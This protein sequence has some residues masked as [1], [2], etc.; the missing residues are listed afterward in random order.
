MGRVDLEDIAKTENIVALCDGIGITG[1]RSIQAVP[2][3]KRF[4]DYR[5]MLD[6][7]DI[8][9]VIVATDHTYAIISMEAIRQGK[10]VYTEKR[11]RIP[12][13]KPAC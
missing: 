6:K 1:S 2:N 10:H 8:D 13:K 12:Y 3:A 7:Q 9:A 5:E 11:S 4:K